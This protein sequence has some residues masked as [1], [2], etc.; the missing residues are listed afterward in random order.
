MVREHVADAPAPDVDE[1]QHGPGRTGRGLRTWAG[2][3]GWGAA[4]AAVLSVGYLPATEVPII[5]DDLMALNETYAVSNGSLW[6]AISFGVT[7]GTEAGHFNPIGQALGATYHYA[8]WAVSASLGVDPQ[9]FDV[10]AYLALIA[11]AVAG[12]A[13]VVVW[14]LSR[15]TRLQPRFWPLFALI[16]AVTAATMQI[17]SLGSNDPVVSF[18]PAGWGS[19]AIGFWT[20]AMALRATSPGVTGRG[21]MV[22]ASLM[23]ISCVWYYEMLVSAVAATAVALVLT[24]TLAVDRATV[25]RR[26]Q[27]LLG[28][29]V[30]L[31]MVVFVVGR[32]LAVPGGD[33]SYGGTTV[34]LGTDA[35][36]TWWTGMVGALPGA[37]WNFLT[38]ITGPPVLRFDVMLLGGL[39][40][41]IVGGI[42]YAWA[43]SA[44]RTDAPLAGVGTPADDAA[45][46]GRS[47]VAALVAVVVTFWALAT[48]AHSVAV[49]YIQEIQDFGQ[50]YLFYAVGV[51]AFATLVA[52]ALVA[53]RPRARGVVLLALVPVVGGFVLAQ[54]SVNVAVA[55]TTRRMVPH[56]GPL[57]A[58]STD[59]DA[60]ESQRCEVLGQWLAQGFA[61]HYASAISVDLQEN[62]ERKFGEPFCSTI[63]TGRR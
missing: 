52:V 29:A 33:T 37:G 60:P 20:I 10:L 12:A 54:F 3:L 57:V 4:G 14:G 41:L 7:E 62:Y 15:S 30:A 25:R 28:T 8:A 21:W 50:V 42:G 22:G 27:V 24:A 31:P 11:L 9:Y 40:C 34:A 18:G 46:A 1:Q 55:E 45:P 2:R 58:L 61:P 19:A 63:E 13:S 47:P 53:L 6:R 5:A 43:R 38:E 59:A 16:C 17:H 23:A 36:E 39:L 48:A 26:C 56:N 49:K 35:L 44:G 51:V 32:T